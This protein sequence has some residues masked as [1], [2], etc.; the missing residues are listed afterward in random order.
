MMKLLVVPA[1]S[2]LTFS[3]RFYY[4]FERPTVME[5]HKSEPEIIMIN[6]ESYNY[7]WRGL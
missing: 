1:C 7:R 5:Y 6:V 4:I 2:D 3:K